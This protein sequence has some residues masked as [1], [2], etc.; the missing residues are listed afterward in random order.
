MGAALLVDGTR[1]PPELADVGHA[2]SRARLEVYVR[3][4]ETGVVHFL[5]V[6]LV[7]DPHPARDGVKVRLQVTGRPGW[8]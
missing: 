4:G 8:T 6:Q 7:D 1:L 2:V 5:P 3:H